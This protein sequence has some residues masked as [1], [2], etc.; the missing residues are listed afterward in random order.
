M[1]TKIEKDSYTGTDTTGHE[2][3]GIKELNTPIPSWWVW[4]FVASIIFSIVY[5]ILYPA[6][7][8]TDSATQGVLGW[9]QRDTLATELAVR[10]EGRADITASI[11]EADAA[12][13]EQDHTLR[14]FALRGGAA[15]FAENC[16]PCHGAGG[17]GRPGYPVLADDDWI[18]GGT[19]SAIQETIRV[20]IRSG[21]DDERYAEMPAFADMLPQ[22]ERIAIAHFVAGFT[23]TGDPA[24]AAA[25]AVPYQD[26]CASCHGEDGTAVE[27]TGAPSLNDA[28]WIYGSDTGSILK[29]ISNP[30]HGVMPAWEGRLDP[31]T[32][33]MLAI[34]VHNLGGGLQED[35]G[36]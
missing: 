25:G 20:G 2:W 32:I 24:K 11:S 34:Y 27:D 7:P 17:G 10:D 12:M 33:K 16:A 31:V 30:Q 22:G 21:H 6:I 19:L 13:V 5:V 23:D 36:L 1:P 15:A 8:L 3:D 28:I 35:A 18:W 9:S 14:T 26:N 29:Q 4:V